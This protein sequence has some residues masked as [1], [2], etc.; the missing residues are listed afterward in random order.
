L[1]ADLRRPAREASKRI[2]DDIL[3]TAGEDLEDPSEYSPTVV[4][5]NKDILD[6]TF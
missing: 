5:M 4:K 3:L 6:D 1:V 2:V